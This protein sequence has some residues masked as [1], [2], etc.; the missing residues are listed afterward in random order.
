MGFFL[1]QIFPLTACFATGANEGGF[2]NSTYTK[3]SL[4][5]V[6]FATYFSVIRW[7]LR[8]RPALCRQRPMGTAVP[9]QHSGVH[10]PRGGRHQV[11]EQTGRSVHRLYFRHRP[12]VSH[13]VKDKAIITY[14]CF[15]KQKKGA[16]IRSTSSRM[17]WEKPTRG[18]R[19][20]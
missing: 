3:V 13:S 20:G 7:L 2:Y 19:T 4:A 14:M 10:V 12:L 11:Q 9:G 17:R 8:E 5:S 18:P 6:T 16:S 1:S 15:F